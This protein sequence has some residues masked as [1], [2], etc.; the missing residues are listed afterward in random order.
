M[1]RNVISRLSDITKFIPLSFELTCQAQ[2]CLLVLQYNLTNT[3]RSSIEIFVHSVHEH[4]KIKTIYCRTDP[5][6]TP[7]Q[8]K[9]AKLKE[10]LHFTPGW[11]HGN[12]NVKNISEKHQNVE[13][14]AINTGY[15]INNEVFLVTLVGPP[16]SKFL[17]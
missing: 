5:L 11:L 2:W 14:K 10:R 9:T 12:E 16:F 13:C 15:A 8:T 4:L 17:K 6:V 3:L 7:R 1:W